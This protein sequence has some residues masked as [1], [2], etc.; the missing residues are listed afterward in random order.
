MAIYYAIL[1]LV[2]PGKEVIGPDPGFPTY[3]SVIKM[4]NA[5]PIRVPLKEKK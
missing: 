3:Y 2:D 1:C 5:I 4:C